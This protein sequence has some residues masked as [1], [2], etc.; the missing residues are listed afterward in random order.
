MLKSRFIARIVF[1]ILLLT[2]TFF[3]FK[4]NQILSIYEFVVS[5]TLI[6]IFVIT[7]TIFHMIFLKK[8]TWWLTFIVFIVALFYALLCLYIPEITAMHR[9]Y[10]T[11]RFNYK[12]LV[13]PMFI[14]VI[15]VFVIVL[16]YPRKE[17]D[18]P[19]KHEILDN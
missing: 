14:A 15:V 18:S 12:A 1:T 17:S 10:L 11:S 6:Y 3:Y 2:T 13:L 5:S 8:L 4:I 9:D 7:V 19:G 16:F